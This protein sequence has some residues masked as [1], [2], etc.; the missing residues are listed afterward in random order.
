M[1]SMR[2]AALL[3]LVVLVCSVSGN[4]AEKEKRFECLGPGGGGQMY[5]TGISPHNPRIMH[6]SCDMGTFYVS[7]DGGEHWYMVDSLQMTGIKSTR[8]GY[9]PTKPGVVYMPYYR[10]SVKQLRVSHD[11][12]KHWEVACDNV[13]WGDAKGRD[14]FERGLTAIDFDA[15]NAGLMFVSTAAGLFR[16]TDEGKTFTKCEGVDGMAI[17]AYISTAS[18]REKRY[19]IAATSSGV[20]ISQDSGMT[21]KKKGEGLSKSFFAFCAA[22]NKKTGKVSCYITRW[23]KVFVSHDSGMSFTETPLKPEKYTGCYRFLTMAQTDPLTAYVSSFG[24]HYGVWKT[25]DGGKSWNKVLHQRYPG[26]EYGWV[27]RMIGKGWGGRPNRITCDPNN[28]DLITAVNTMEFFLSKDG[29]KTWKEQC[30]DYKGPDPKKIENKY[31]WSGVGLEVALPTNLVFDP[32]V[33][34][35]A[36]IIYGDIG[37]LISEDHCKS[38]RRSVK[39]IPNKWIL[40]MFDCVPD[41]ERKGVLFAAVSGVHGI[42]QNID[43]IRKGGGVVMSSDA[44]ET[45]KVIS[46]GLDTSKPCTSLVMDMKSPKNKRTLYCV[47]QTRGVYRSLDDGAT[48]EKKSA[49]IGRPNNPNVIHVRLGPDGAVYALLSGRRDSKWKFRFG[50]GGLWRS[51]DKGETWVEIT[52][53]LHIVNPVNFAVDPR[54]ARRIMVAT[55]QAPGGES[56]GLFET[57]DCGR[58]WKQIVSTKVTGKKLYNYIHA[59]PVTFHPKY[60]DLIYFS[61]KTHGLWISRDNAK[62]WRRMLGIP[63]IG[64]HRRITFDPGNPDIMYVTSVGLWKGPAQGY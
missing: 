27:G 11:R 2:Q 48:W 15:E 31:P 6:T 33:K 64:S 43:G 44:G 18:P 45:W 8:P 56:A 16:S 12:G 50:A 35:R 22:T 25:T 53:G 1:T 57:V 41:P 61:T 39:G 60:E 38:W 29:G 46:K 9:H 37:F 10:N 21:W 13:P 19:C 5:G 51:T 4:A 62:T 26:L 54:N 28:P 47:I 24:S 32:F 59:G 55:S 40:R 20:F 23:D 36:Y 58:K 3:V 7:E 52:K 30:A 14:K 63:R 49:G 42:T 34:D 17:G